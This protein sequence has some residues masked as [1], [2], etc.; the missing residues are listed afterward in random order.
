VIFFVKGV[1]F[2]LTSPL[3][4]DPISHVLLHL[5]FLTPET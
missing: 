4:G 1:F 3:M 5:L 2:L